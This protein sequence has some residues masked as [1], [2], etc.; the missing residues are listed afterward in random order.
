MKIVTRPLAELRLMEKNIRRHT[1]RQLKE[2]VRS[3]EM[4]GQLRPAVIDEDGTVLAGNGLVQALRLAGKETCD[5]FVLSGLT[6]AQKKKVMLS[7][8]RV[9][10]L[11]YTDTQ[12]FDEI[13]RDLEGDT[14]V[15]GWDPDL[16]EMLSATVREADE[17][18]RQYGVGD[19]EPAAPARQ[20]PDRS[21]A[22]VAPPG[23]RQAPA[24]A[25]RVIVC[26]SCGETIC[27]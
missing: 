7:D 22:A 25:Q 17:I 24:P 9:Y 20:A 26:P 10:E 18:I 2:Y 19:P 27:L 12:V 16:L 4:W 3:V 6:E 8:N 14:D 1:D 23:E 15:P 13:I 11:G 5:C 21:P